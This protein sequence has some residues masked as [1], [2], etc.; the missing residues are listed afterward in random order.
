MILAAGRLI[1]ALGWWGTCLRPGYCRGSMT[2][3]EPRDLR[4][5]VSWLGLAG[6]LLN[7]VNDVS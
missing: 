3:R 2:G 7:H 5:L 4:R 1:G 6:D